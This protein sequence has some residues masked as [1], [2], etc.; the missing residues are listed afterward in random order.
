MQ[1]RT[2][3]T[4]VAGLLLPA[5]WPTLTLAQQPQRPAGV[6]TALEGEAVV[7]RAALPQPHALK[8]RDDVFARDRIS[9]REKSF[10]RVLLGGKAV[11]TVRE[12]SNLTITEQAGRPSIIELLAGKIALVVARFR[13]TPG[14]AIEIHTPNAVAALR[15]TVVIVEVRPGPTASLAA[16]QVSFTEVFHAV[17][18]SLSICPPGPQPCARPV[19]LMP[20]NSLDVFGGVIRNPYPSP[21]RATLLAGWTAPKSHSN[22]PPEAVQNV[23]SQHQT[24]FQQEAQSL[25][26]Q[27]LSSSSPP[28]LTDRPP[29]TSTIGVN[30][31]NADKAAAAEAAALKQA[32]GT[33]INPPP[34]PPRPQAT[35][36]PPP[37]LPPRPQPPS[38]PPPPGPRP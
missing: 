24:R 18:D 2:L 22:S 35:P 10:V 8:F 21:P 33:I 30:A 17:S 26:G 23:V 9:T 14:D 37:P 27:P 25:T 12:L 6:V 28:P 15:G 13:M 32:T 36:P 4:L 7:A 20:G 31:T 38:P 29:S 16:A 11:V 19:L 3:S 5:I 34:F 1:R